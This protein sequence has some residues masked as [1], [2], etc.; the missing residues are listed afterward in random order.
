[1]KKSIL[2]LISLLMLFSLNSCLLDEEV[3]LKKDG[4][5]TVHVK[6]ELPSYLLDQLDTLSASLPIK[7]EE[8][9]NPK[10]I[11]E[12]LER[13]KNL[14]NIKVSS[15]STG[16]IDITFQFDKLSHI[17][18]EATKDTPKNI[19][20][21]EKRNDGSQY[22]KAH[23]DR[24]AY[25]EILKL[26]P[27]LKSNMLIQYYGPSSNAITEEDY[28]DMI[29]YSFGEKAKEEL[30]QTYV[31]TTIHLV[32]GTLIGQENGQIIKNNSVLYKV[33][34][35]ELALLRKSFSYAIQFK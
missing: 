6:I 3:F 21:W 33:P 5:G 27:L 4:S 22:I 11:K 7:K 14:S 9:L 35:L 16:K 34:L 25:Q 12:G 10:A 17:L 18:H 23:F 2:L 8:I 30:P 15:N 20:L 13:N 31:N 29:E 28:L 19:L 26:A 24:K 1:M 32:D